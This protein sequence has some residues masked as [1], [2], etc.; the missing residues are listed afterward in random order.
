MLAASAGKAGIRC[1]VIDLFAD[2]D[3][4]T[5]A[6]QTATAALQ[7]YNFRADALLAAA[8][9]L[10]P[11]HRCGV[12]YGSGFEAD[13]DVLTE[14]CRK[15][16]LLGNCPATI[17]AVKQPKRLARVLQTLNIPHPEIRFEAPQTG[18]WL[19]KQ[20]GACG[21][22]HILRV[23]LSSTQRNA[24]MYYQRFVEGRQLS[25]TLL[26][27]GRDTTI[28]GFCEQWHAG[29]KDHP[30]TYGGAVVLHPQALPEYLV[31]ELHDA[32]KALTG[33]VGLRGLWGID[34][35]AT[36]ADWWLLE[37]NPRPCATL[38]LHESGNSLLPWHI[39]AAR[40]PLPIDCWDLDFATHRGHTIVYAQET[41]TVP[42]RD[43]PCWI[44]DRP[45]AGTLIRPGEPV[46]TV[47][48]QG[49]T[50]A[51]VRKKL[52]RACAAVITDL[53]GS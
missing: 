23:C 40:G 30:F 26:S 35:I 13:P 22:S 29:L 24:G 38:E 52:S 46:C 34:L 15:R 3:S 53:S 37:I 12:I 32:A 19:E 36:E 43:W 10:D 33:Q 21:G 49:Q 4:Q 16:P 1:K 14:L 8:D 7:G 9:R 25:V 47:Y 51:A 5:L 50:P 11:E 42:E 48:A 6:E 28:I 2:L 20:T 44:S 41:L 17:D 39:A 31:S 27:D 45:H 18:D